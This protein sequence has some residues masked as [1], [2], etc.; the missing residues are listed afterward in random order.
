MR[1]IYKRISN[2]L[3]EIASFFIRYSGILFLI[4][5][6][7]AKKKVSIIVY[8]NPKPDI[9]DKHLKYLSKRYNFISLDSLVNAIH[10]KNWANIPQRGLVITLDDGHK[11]NFDLLKSFKKYGVVPTIYLCSQISNT[12]R[13][14]W[15][16]INGV[17]TNVLKK[18][19]NRERIIFLREK[20]GFTPTKEYPEEQRQALNK[21]EI[22]LMNGFVD[23]QSHSRFHP[24]LTVCT[25]DECKKEIVQSKN[26]IEELLGEKCKHFAYPNG[27]YTERE[28]EL[29]K[30]AGY[31]SARTI[32]VGWNDIKTNPYKLKAKMVTDN[33]SINLLAAQLSGITQF[34]RY[35]LKGGFTGKYHTVRLEEASRKN[36]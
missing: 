11:G 29:V 16:R 35:F 23:F 10:S 4:R 18:Y 8:H 6:I 3:K 14:Y 32:D 9:L 21:K 15:F 24:I 1:D 20:F 28:I 22:M 30:K 17:D 5:N 31:L 7:Y 25:Y 19:S 36:D 2:L 26:E 12:N 34:F 27:D 13:H 33:A